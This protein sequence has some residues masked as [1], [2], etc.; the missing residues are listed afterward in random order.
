MDEILFRALV[1]RVGGYL[2][3]VERLASGQS[4]EATREL[5]RLA[6]A[7]RSLL[8]LHAPART[9]RKGR[10]VG[11]RASRGSPGMCTVWRVAG[12][13]FVRRVPGDGLRG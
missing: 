11:C 10:C 12:D 8:G 3:G 5:R 13:W 9:G 4:W 2:E 1:E 7:W 6:G